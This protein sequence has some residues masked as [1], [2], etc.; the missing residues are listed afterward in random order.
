M[1]IYDEVNNK[2]KK[3]GDSVANEDIRQEIADSDVKKWEIADMLGIHISTF[4]VRLRHEMTQAQKDEIRMAIRQIKKSEA[5][6]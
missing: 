6:A 4:S 2:H 5:T 1:Q 3:R